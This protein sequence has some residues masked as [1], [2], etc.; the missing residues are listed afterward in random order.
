MR[1]YLVTC[2]LNLVEDYNK[3]LK[4]FKETFGDKVTTW[5]DSGYEVFKNDRVNFL[6]KYKPAN[7]IIKQTAN[8]FKQI[9]KQQNIILNDE[10]AEKLVD[11][12]IS[13]ADLERGFKLKSPSDVYFKIPDFFVAK[14]FADRA[15]NLK[16]KKRIVTET[17][18]VL[19]KRM[20]LSD[21]PNKLIVVDGVQVNRREII[22]KLLGKTNDPMSTILIGTNRLASIIRRNEMFDNLLRKSNQQRVI[23]DDWIKGGR[24]GPRPEAPTFVN[25]Q[26]EAEK[27]LNAAPDEI[28]QL[29]FD[30]GFDS[31]A[32]KPVDDIERQLY[33]ELDEKITNPLANKFTLKGNA[34][35]IQGV[36]DSLLGKGFGAQ[37]YQNLVLYPKATF[38]W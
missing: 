24:Q 26:V 3:S 12:V 15:A 7:Q 19:P 5:L 31:A 33:D 27:Y 23:Y 14:S 10:T 22:E 2:F 9:A 8:Q 34:E 1:S 17:A 28:E 32:T 4:T 29:R 16:P 13:T 20:Q 37:L 21:I 35:A 6:K 30:S 18:Q 38:K 11:R 25:S 36:E